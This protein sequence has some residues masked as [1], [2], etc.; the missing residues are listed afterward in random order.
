MNVSLNWLNGHLDLSNHSIQELDDLLTFAGVEVEGIQQQGLSTE[1]VVVAQIK[2][3]VQHPVADRL[4]ICQVDAGE[5]ASMLMN[6]AKWVSS[7]D[8]DKRMDAL[9]SAMGQCFLQ[10]LDL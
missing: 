8:G 6:A 3:A 1:L 5:G 9:A 10:V 2:E 7:T 4:K